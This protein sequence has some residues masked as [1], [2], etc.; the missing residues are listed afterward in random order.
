MTAKVVAQVVQAHHQAAQVRAVTTLQV[1]AQVVVSRVMTKKERK[2][3][4][5]EN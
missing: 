5:Y 1:E 3:K 4:Q 2:Q